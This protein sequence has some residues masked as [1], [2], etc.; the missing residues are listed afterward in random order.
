MGTREVVM[1]RENSRAETN[2]AT[3]L[4]VARAGG[5]Y[6]V[7]SPSA[8]GCEIAWFL[9]HRHHHILYIPD[10]T[11]ARVAVLLGHGS[12]RIESTFSCVFWHHFFCECRC[13][14]PLPAPA[15]IALLEYASCYGCCG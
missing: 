14:P 1:R 6:A 2:R 11:Y 4:A 12:P 3:A 9:S 15:S 10:N 5:V 7:V 8:C 13:N